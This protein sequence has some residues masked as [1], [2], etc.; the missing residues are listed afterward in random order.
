M[1]WTFLGEIEEES[2]TAG[3]WERIYLLVNQLGLPHMEAELDPTHCPTCR[4]AHAVVMVERDAASDEAFSAVVS[5]PADAL[6]TAFML[7][8]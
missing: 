5:M 4:I 3:E 1:G 7:E 6:V 2:L 8:E